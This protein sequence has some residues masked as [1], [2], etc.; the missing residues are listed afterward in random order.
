M[1]DATRDNA[2]KIQERA[3]VVAAW[4]TAP[5]PVPVP[6]PTTTVD[7]NLACG[8]VTPECPNSNLM[9]RQRFFFG[10]IEACLSNAA[11]TRRRLFRRWTCGGC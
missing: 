6:V 2:R 10:C 3:P 1:G 11:A 9:K 7:P 5:V 4:K 8:I